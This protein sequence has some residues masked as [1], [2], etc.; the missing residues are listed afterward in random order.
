MINGRQIRAARGLLK[1]SS[2]V[3]A[4]KSGLTRETINKIED[5][6]VHPREGTLH[7]IIR[8]FSENGVEF[9]GNRGV[10][11][12]DD[13]VTL[14]G[15]NSFFHVLDDVIATLKNTKG[16]E[17]LFFCVNDRV[18]PPTI[19][20]N[21][22]RLRRSGI[23]MRSLVKEGDTYLMGKLH[24]YRYLPQQFFHN[25][26]SLIYSNKF[27][28]MILDPNTGSDIGAIIIRNPHIASAQRNIFNL[29]W[30]TSETPTETTATV[31]YDE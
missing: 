26:T 27:A 15:E 23:A 31:R 2:L 18:S 13:V 12:K 20:E 22:R 10:A 16:A 4:E 5:E 25:N 1:W 9:I 29:I 28:T 7:D 14:N 17:V 11:L 8:V 30:S 19:V 21:Y 6:S 24:E 3:L